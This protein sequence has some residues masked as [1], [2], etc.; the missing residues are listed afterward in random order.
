MDEKENEVKNKNSRK[1]NDIDIKG[2]FF[3]I[4]IFI[5][6]CI[7]ILM[8]YSL[9]DKI[10]SSK[11]IIEENNSNDTVSEIIQVEVL[12]GCGVSGIAER[13]TDYLRANKCDVVSSSNYSDYDV[14]RTIVVDRIGNRANAKYVADILGVKNIVTEINKDYFLDVSVIIGR[15]FN[16][17]KPVK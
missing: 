17:L 1:G 2:T 4:I 8:S 13:F 6:V 14:P 9:Y 10:S 11:R 15:D 16:Q 12:N 5:L 3:Y 7:I